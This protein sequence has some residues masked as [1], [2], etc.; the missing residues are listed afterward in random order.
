MYHHPRGS[1]H[2]PAFP[3]PTRAPSPGRQ[4]HPLL[5]QQPLPFLALIS[6]L[7]DLVDTIV[8]DFHVLPT[9]I[10]LPSVMRTQVFSF[11]AVMD[12]VCSTV[13]WPSTPSLPTFL[14]S[15]LRSC[16]FSLPHYPQLPSLGA[17]PSSSHTR[18]GISLELKLPL[19]LF[20]P[21]HSVPFP[22]LTMKHLQ[23]SGPSSPLL[24][25][26]STLSN[27]LLPYGSTGESPDDWPPLR[28]P[29][30]RSAQCL[31]ALT[32]TVGPSLP[33][34]ARSF[35]S[36]RAALSSSFCFTGRS[37]FVTF[38]GSS[39]TSLC[40]SPEL[41]R[42]PLC[43]CFFLISLPWLEDPASPEA[44]NTISCCCHQTPELHP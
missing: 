37:F 5:S 16:S 24:P 7:R 20:F 44:S 4:F 18:Y 13:R 30:Q 25:S 10:N 21:S 29:S 2:P 3:S 27:R 14:G 17:F 40:S 41:L 23:K 19:L 6:N 28:G 38:V 12:E 8:E 43:A 35:L 15:W 1:S 22:P 39:S 26:F 31:S 9:S 34:E 42:P 36:F 11:R 32:Q 33:Y